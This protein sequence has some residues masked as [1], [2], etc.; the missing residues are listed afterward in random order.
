MAANKASLRAD[1]LLFEFADPN[2]NTYLRV[3]DEGVADAGGTQRRS[4]DMGSFTRDGNG[5]VVLSSGQVFLKGIAAPASGTANMDSYV[6]PISYVNERVSTAVQ[7]LSVRTAVDVASIAALTITD[8]SASVSNATL[9]GV[10]SLGVG[11][12]ESFRALLK[13]QSDPIENGLY[14]LTVESTGPLVVALARTSDLTDGEQAVGVTVFVDQGSSQANTTWVCTQEGIVGTDALVWSIMA[15]A[16]ELT[17]GAGLSK[18]GGTLSV[19]VDGSTLVVSGNLRVASGGIE[20]THLA[21]GAVTGA[22]LGA[23]ADGTTIEL[24]GGTLT[25]LPPASLAQSLNDQIMGGT[26]Y[27]GVAHAASTAAISLTGGTFSSDFR[28]TMGGWAPTTGVYEVLLTQQTDPIENGLYTMT[29]SSSGASYGGAVTRSARM[30]TGT[31]ITGFSVSITQSYYQDRVFTCQ[32]QSGAEVGTDALQWTRRRP[33]RDIRVDAVTIA[34]TAGESPG[35]SQR[36]SMVLSF[37]LLSRT[38][39]QGS[40]YTIAILK[41]ASALANGV[42]RVTVTQ[43][44]DQDYTCDYQRLDIWDYD[45]DLATVRLYVHPDAGSIYAGSLLVCID[46]GTL[47]TIGGAPHMQ[48]QAQI[49][50]VVDGSG[51]SII[52]TAGDDTT[53]STTRVHLVTDDSTI[54]VSPGG[55]LT[56]VDGGIGTDQL[57]TSIAINSLDV[58]NLSV[59]SFAGSAITVNAI[60]TPYINAYMSNQFGGVLVTVPSSQTS[61]TAFGAN[62]LF[63]GITHFQVTLI[64]TTPATMTDHEILWKSGGFSGIGLLLLNDY[65]LGSRVGTGDPVTTGT[66][67]DPSTQYAT[68]VV[69]N[70]TT[71]LLEIHYSAAGNFDWYTVDRTPDASGT[72][73]G[74]FRG[75][76]GGG[77][78]QE[79]GSDSLHLA[80]F[81]TRGPFH[82]TIDSDMVAYSYPSMA[83]TIRD[84]SDN[85][86][87]SLT[88]A[89][90]EANLPSGSASNVVLYN[91]G[92]GAM[93]YDN[94]M[95]LTSVTATSLVA[96][97]ASVA[98]ID[99]SAFSVGGTLA[100]DGNRDLAV[101]DVSG[102]N[103]IFDRMDASL[104]TIKG[105]SFVDDQRNIEALSLSITDMQTTDASIGTL[106]VGTVIMGSTII[107]DTMG[108]V[109]MAPDILNTTDL[110]VTDG[111]ITTLGVE[112]LTVTSGEITTGNVVSLES[113]DASIASLDVVNMTLSGTTVLSGSTLSIANIDA[114]D[115]SFSTMD[116]STL[117]MAGATFVDYL[118]NVTALSVSTADMQTTDASIA[119]LEVGTVIMGSTI[120]S[121]TMGTVTMAPDVL[122]ATDLRATDASITSL[123]IE[124]LTV[125]GAAVL[126]SGGLTLTNASVGSLNVDSLTLTNPGI[127]NFS[128]I[129]FAKTNDTAR[130]RVTETSNDQTLFQFYMDDNPSASG[131]RWEWYHG[132]FRGRG[133]HWLPIRMSAYDIRFQAIDMTMLGALHVGTERWYGSEGVVDQIYEHARA[134]TNSFTVDISGAT[135]TVH[136]NIKVI[137]TTDG[138]TFTATE[139][140]TSN[141]VYVADVAITGG[142]QEIVDGITITFASTSGGVAGDEWHFGV[143]PEGGI[144]STVGYDV[145]G[146]TIVDADRDTSFRHVRGSS[147]TA[148]DGSFGAMVT[149]THTV[150]AADPALLLDE[151]DGDG[152][153]ELVC[154]NGTFRVKVTNSAGF[155]GTP[156]SCTNQG[157][158]VNNIYT[159][160]L[161]SSTSGNPLTIQAEDSSITLDADEIVCGPLTTTSIT[162]GTSTLGNATASKLTTPYLNAATPGQFGLV[163]SQVVSTGSFTAFGADP[164]FTGIDKIQ[165]TLIF[166]TPGPGVMLDN[167]VIWESGGVNGIGL[168][169]LTDYTLIARAGLGDVISTPP[170]AASTQYATVVV[171]DQISKVLE[172]HYATAADFDW[173]TSD[174]TAEVEGASAGNYMGTDSGGLGSN[175][176]ACVFDNDGLSYEAFRGSI[177]SN[178]MTYAFPAPVFAIRDPNDAT[179]FALGDG[180]TIG[181][182][183]LPDSA[184]APPSTVLHYD[185]TTGQV[186]Y[187]DTIDIDD[188]TVN[189]L[190]PTTLSVGGTTVLDANRN[191][192][193]N[194]ATASSLVVP[195][196]SVANGPT[197]ALRSADTTRF[198]PLLH[199]MTSAPTT[200]SEWGSVIDESINH[201]QIALNFTTPANVDAGCI[202]GQVLYETSG[203]Y[204]STRYGLSLILSP[205][206]ELEFWLDRN[207]RFQYAVS[208]STAYSSVVVFKS[209]GY[210]G[211]VQLHLVEGTDAAFTWYSITRSAEA[212]GTFESTEREH[213]WRDNTDGNNNAGFGIGSEDR[214]H[215]VGGYNAGKRGVA[216]NT[217][218]LGTMD[219]NLEIYAYPPQGWNLTVSQGSDQVLSLAETDAYLG[220]PG[221]PSI[222][223]S[224]GTQFG[225][226]LYRI[227]KD[228]VPHTGASWSDIIPTSLRKIQVALSFRT[229]AGTPS[230]DPGEILYETGGS[231]GGQ[232]YGLSAILNSSHELEI[233]F[234]GQARI[235]TVAFTP[236]TDYSTVLVYDDDANTLSLS[237]EEGSTTFDWYRASLTPDYTVSFGSLDDRIISPGGGD[238]GFGT[239]GGSLGAMP[240]PFNQVGADFSGTM[241]SDLS[242]YEFPDLDWSLRISDNNNDPILTF[243]DGSMGLHDIRDSAANPPGAVLHYDTTTGEVS[244]SDTIDIDDITVNTLKPTTLSVGGT[245]VL[246][247]NRNLTVNDATASSLTV[248]TI[249][250]ANGPT[251]SLSSAA[252]ASFGPLITSMV[253]PTYPNH[254]F[255]PSWTSLFDET[256]FMV[257]VNFTTPAIFATSGL[258]EG[259]GTMNPPNTNIIWENGGFWDD[260]VS[261]IS[262]I[263]NTSFM[264]YVYLNGVNLSAQFAAS[265]SYSTVLVVDSVGETGTLSLHVQSDATTPFADFSWF[266]TSRSPEFTG[267]WST[268]GE[269][270]RFR[271]IRF[272]GF[273]DRSQGPSGDNR[274]GGYGNLAPRN[275]A[276][277]GTFDSDLYVYKYPEDSWSLVTTVGGYTRHALRES[278]AYTSVHG[279]PKVRLTALPGVQFG[280][281]V[282]SMTWSPGGITGVSWSDIIDVSVTKLQVAL[283]FTTPATIPGTSVPG[284][285]IWETGGMTGGQQYGISL[286]I[287]S[288]YQLVTY[289][290][291]TAAITTT[292]LAPSTAYSTVYIYDS[293]GYDGTVA[294]HITTGTDATFSWYTALRDPD[295]TGAWANADTENTYRIGLPAGFGRMGDSGNVA[296][297]RIGGYNNSPAPV[298]HVFTGTMDSDLLIYA[299]PSMGWSFEIED[300]N[301]NALL[302]LHDGSMGLHAIPTSATSPPLNV[303]LYDDATGEVSYSDVIDTTEAT[304]TTLTATTMGI[305]GTTVIDAD[306]DTDFRHI[307]GTSVTATDGSF[308]TMDAGS[309]AL[310]GYTVLTL[311]GTDVDASLASITATDGSIGT[312]DVGSLAL[313]GYTIM[314]VDGTDVDASLASITA[315]DG[316][317]GTLDAGSLA[318]GGYTIMTVDGADVDASLA[319][320]T[321]TDG[322]FGTMNT[323]IV[324]GVQTQFGAL[325]D[326][327]SSNATSFNA[328]NG[329]SSSRFQVTVVLTTPGSLSTNEIIWESGGSSGIGLILLGGET[330]YFAS[331][332]GSGNVVQSGAIVLGTQYATVVV[333]DETTDLLEIHFNAASSFDWYTP[334]RTPEASG[335]SAGGFRGGNSAGLTTVQGSSVFDGLYAYGDFSGT[336][337]SNLNI[338]EFPSAVIFTL[339]DHEGN[340]ALTVDNTYNLTT[341]TVTATDGSFTNLYVNG[342][343]FSPGAIPL[344]LGLNTLDILTSIDI[345]DILFV[346]SA[347]NVTARN[348]LGLDASFSTLRVDTIT[349]GSLGNVVLDGSDLVGLGALTTADLTATDASLSTLRVDTITLGS[350]GN[351]VLDGSDLVGLSALTTADLTA[352]DAS[353]STLR[354]DTITLG[355][356]GNV[357]LDG[358]DLVGLGA[359]TTGD[360]TATDASLSTLRVDTITLG[361]LGNV[362][363]DGSDLV[364]LSAL[365]TTDLTATNVTAGSLR[366]EHDT[367]DYF[368][369]EVS[370]GGHV[371]FTPSLD[372]TSPNA[373]GSN[374][375]RYRRSSMGGWIFGEGDIPRGL[376]TIQRSSTIEYSSDQDPSDNGRFMTIQNP[377][378]DG[379]AN[380]YTNVTLQISPSLGIGSGVD[381]GR[382][383]ADM[384][385]VRKSANSSN[386]FF[387]WSAFQAVGGYQD[388]L[389]LD[390][391]DTAAFSMPVNTPELQIGGTTAITSGRD[392]SLANVDA[393]SFM[394][395][396]T[397]VISSN[398][399][400]SLS[401]IRVD[402][403]TLGSL[404][405]VVLDGSDLV[406][407]GAL[408]T[409]DLTAT[410]ASLSTLRVDTITLGSLGNVVLDGS[411][412]V[413]LGALTTGDLTA[414]D[415]SLST[416][417]VDTITL[418]SLGNVV[419]DG[420]DLVGLGA[421]TT[422][423]LTATD[424]SLSTLRVDTITLGSLGNVVLDGSD[425]V[426]LGALTTGDLT[427]TDASLS[428]L[429]VDTITLGS[430]GNVVLDGS[431]L[432]GL[433]A[434]TTGDL[435]ATDASLSTLRV[436]TITL[437]SLGNVVLDG[438]DLVGLGAL[439][440]ADLTATDASFTTL[441]VDTITLNTVVVADTGLTIDGT[442]VIDAARNVDATTLSIGGTEVIDGTRNVE[443]TSLSIG[444]TTIVDSNGTLRSVEDVYTTTVSQF[445]TELF[446]AAPNTTFTAFQNHFTAT[447]FQV[448][449]VITTND[450]PQDQSIWESGGVTGI[451]LY[452]HNYRL[453]GR[454]SSGGNGAIIETDQLDT[455]TQYAIVVV[456]DDESNIMEIHYEKAADFDW[457]DVNRTPDASGETGNNYKGSSDGGV[458]VVSGSTAMDGHYAFRNF[459]GTI[460][461]DLVIYDYPSPAGR[462]FRI[463][464][465][466]E[467]VLLSLRRGAMETT[468]VSTTTL[469]TTIINL[470]GP[471]IFSSDA[472]LGYDTTAIETVTAD[473]SFTALGDSFPTIP[474]FY[475]TCSF[476]TPATILATADPGEVIWE[477]GG[478]SGMSLILTPSF[479]LVMYIFNVLG[480]ALRYP[481]Q[482]STTYATVFVYDDTHSFAELH[483]KVSTTTFEWFTPTRA[484]EAVS[485][486]SWPSG[487]HAG[488]GVGGY[489]VQGTTATGGFG[490]GTDTDFTG[491][492]YT[493]LTVHGEYPWACAI[494]GP[495]DTAALTVESRGI[496]TEHVRSTFANTSALNVNDTLRLRSI[497]LSSFTEAVTA[498]NDVTWGEGNVLTNLTSTKS[499]GTPLGRWSSGVFTFHERGLYEIYFNV[500]V[501]NTGYRDRACCL[502]FLSINDVVISDDTDA[503]YGEKM[504]A[505]TYIREDRWARSGTMSLSTV[506][507]MD[508]GDN[509]RLKTACEKGGNST[510]SST[511]S[512]TE[513]RNH[514]VFRVRY[515]GQ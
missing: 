364:G 235:T 349:L 55:A 314:T 56:V 464:D 293:D 292:A 111:S 296:L 138:T 352:T 427:A 375:F 434:L 167:E 470:D 358:S 341:T 6:A 346:D 221:A 68:V 309:L 286:V 468:A 299:F 150:Y 266:T 165:C 498:A 489:G 437:G 367:E 342:E 190:K 112:T 469:T 10:E 398:R 207:Y 362:V 76:N 357:V 510:W 440:T 213:M 335:T 255:A 216:A 399:D 147:V 457:Y 256:K 9:D 90:F 339:L 257:A 176:V 438:S 482:P 446:R 171:F 52:R 334:T 444:G 253:R 281:L 44:V 252:T 429:R 497:Q 193:V 347:R 72:S 391:N 329:I 79:G 404:G 62:P 332:V 262:M 78:G 326:S 107:S 508:G 495:D 369:I 237:Y 214:P 488:S 246:D 471:D 46:P 224:T 466:T 96:T 336:I 201:L 284:M 223:T 406:G 88:D 99:T 155:T 3:L 117:T 32:N 484:P 118:R 122:N 162:S 430:L 331:R 443:A 393:T 423:D 74:N 290:N 436:D 24:S 33:G 131:D 143:W 417:R 57:G 487:S 202:P 343:L 105:Q 188:I 259:N 382:C 416:L 109:T 338:Y 173:Y 11:I 476:R 240:S 21:D 129:N 215:H 465:P 354:V 209:L 19:D 420:S 37:G 301:E 321:A 195:T 449:V 285:V 403:I 145:G 248:P 415:A 153:V 231:H 81:G 108:T 58:T 238:A 101:R 478:I 103:A 504:Y 402:T 313:G 311:D 371:S 337:D 69:Y 414:T 51:T 205:D 29:I 250:V 389:I 136:R 441:G 490:S 328:F 2:D 384:R 220:I 61:F 219:S 274:I 92:T 191:L 385:L 300:H 317:I 368:T 506:I 302:T 174:R 276:F 38:L 244:Y 161:I 83:F 483:V 455:L 41:D 102:R 315:T 378:T 431:D 197:L 63:S 405:N 503:Y 433:S 14:T 53:L 208:P 42:Y 450:L 211:T 507:V 184:S 442:G 1:G 451:A 459:T 474:R 178:L 419:L 34:D 353:L 156:M 275:T 149:E 50:R 283:N 472:S 241:Q 177:D 172:I 66:P 303:L 180:L 307:R 454:V 170:L 54:M 348:V 306:R 23:V 267:T 360:L 49:G 77:L 432:V 397:S 130:I 232:A 203:Q 243:H 381:Q 18:D 272:A 119:T 233:W 100:I 60:T 218:F 258:P 236:S 514:G 247:V 291:G 185:T 181:T 277:Q 114:T 271:S 175:S 363:L 94:A 82:G 35:S 297:V 36:G 85:V 210:D 308:T 91:A 447:K 227:S 386:C 395:S 456:F 5:D 424:A 157:M 228:L 183:T 426:G 460:D 142:A 134:G 16:G 260:E 351:V 279:G 324:Q 4:L 152:S 242:I 135:N 458:G 319:S 8:V 318:L 269:D 164:A 27:R 47:R 477:T 104:L 463:L 305:G 30:P 182:G 481:V 26:V 372:A 229:P 251:L 356:L 289:I 87:L 453:K 439:T 473:S 421:L 383:L 261:G 400:A 513:H 512:T 80:I 361:S 408:T 64:I 120:I 412:L 139:I 359:L 388:M 163:L 226:L 225:T 187:S 15:R 39:S 113:T 310:G 409:A 344:D 189:I 492:L 475:L 28:V 333:F 396:G 491:T 265:T 192:T 97:D 73:S 401:T 493:D 158:Q 392:A 374:S 199:T 154:E 467:T 350:L 148:T 448:T 98:S 48:M 499:Y 20:T 325:F 462:G 169:I 186:S 93:S 373:A 194:D 323:A 125:D 370:D 116:A 200:G 206:M 133:A 345:S 509:I 298:D 179:L 377:T 515:L 264:I 151:S 127:G 425:L 452:T 196:I 294:L 480:Y 106:E 123:D 132:S 230:G 280:T 128:Q 278:S 270:H 140:N 365:S 71:G 121:D 204:G 217:E 413:G 295:H 287:D 70:E 198:G 249:S 273:G 494:R 13:D 316:S 84:P 376:L 501:R 137:L 7:G 268:P 22:K 485:F 479:Q 322:S 89:T 390:P 282:H 160:S 355:S 95:S 59:A 380:Y 166:T 288:S 387:A 31:D 12:G 239:L 45:D 40:V 17:A 110:S 159:V 428:T 144:D 505:T 212:Y 115:A 496:H 327:I 435:T 422:A 25:A 124:A 407:L 304:V 234:H 312:L 245:T 75:A 43:V 330:P 511:L 502:T 254:T 65:T 500:S 461:S 366:V 379:G 141:G 418:G 146:V 320:I 486:Q 86:L 394:V 263:I 411:D 126:D 168:A 222:R 340:T 67:L 445:G 410:D